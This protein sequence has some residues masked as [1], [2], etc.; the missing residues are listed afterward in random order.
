MNM[1]TT[2]HPTNAVRTRVRTRALAHIGLASALAFLVHLATY[3]QYTGGAG[4]GYALLQFVAPQAITTGTVSGPICAGSALVVPFTAEA[5]TFNAGNVFTAELSSADGS[6]AAPVAIGSLSGTSDGSINA[7]IPAGTPAGT[8]YRIRVVSSDPVV[9][10]TNNGVNITITAPPLWYADGDGDGF[11]AGAPVP[12][13]VQPIGHVANNLDCDD[14][15]PAIT[16]IGLA[17]DDGNAGTTNDVITAACTC[18]GVSSAFYAGGIGSGYALLA[19]AAPPIIT[20]GP[21]S[22]PLCAGSTLDLSFVVEG[23]FNTGNAFTA[24][25]SDATG[26]FASPTTI[27]TLTGTTGGTLPVTIPAGTPD[28]GGY[29]IRVVG[30]DPSVVGADNG[31]DITV[32]QCVQLAVRAM[33]EGPYT[34]ATG[35]MNDALRGLPSFPLADPYPGIGYTHVGGGNDGAVAPAVLATAGNDAI[36]DWVLLE[37][38]DESTP[39]TVQS[40]RSALVQRDGDVVELDGS[41]PVRFAL[42]AGSYHVAVRHRNHLG[43]MTG[44]PIAL[45]PT[46]TAVDFTLPATSTFGTNARRSITGAFPAEALW[47]GD[48]TFDGEVK[49]TG[50]TNDRDPQ[51]QAIGGS[52]PTNTATGYLPQD[53]NMDGVVRYVGAANDRDPILQTVGGSVPTNTRLQQLP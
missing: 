51:L 1:T 43:V 22:G 19:F 53:V 5:G 9:P 16:A 32:L 44:G 8:G 14:G 41:S 33:L 45:A 25:L 40:S 37:L 36:V 21:A 29:R 49:Y 47:A 48:V 11:G 4:S 3:G 2:T 30:S 46:I 24:E 17:C 34:S 35:L 50:P 52:V 20:T 23:A 42:P 27:G 26:S 7:V 28:G 10:G 38:R 39:A 6:F 31:V 12:A 15:D 13:C 18:A